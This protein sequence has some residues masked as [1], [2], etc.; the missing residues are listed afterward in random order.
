MPQRCGGA[1]DRSQPAIELSDWERLP[2]H[3]LL[4]DLESQ[5]RSV[6]VLLLPSP[7]GIPVAA[8]WIRD[9][10]RGLVALGTACRPTM[11][12]AVSK[13]LVEAY[14]VLAITIDLADPD[15][16][17]WR[18]VADGTLPAHLY[19]PFRADRRYRDEFDPQWKDIVDLP[20]V[21]QLYLDPVM[22]PGR[23]GTSLRLHRN[24]LGIRDS[25][26]SAVGSGFSRSASDVTGTPA[27]FRR[28]H[29]RRHLDCRVARR[30]HPDSGPVQQR[31]GS[32]SPSWR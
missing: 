14:A 25:R 29:H 16:P 10:R 22:A 23:R 20:T 17:T 24:T 32:L 13:A 15:G 28:S 1:G 18:S 11:E 6:R 8:V 7:F 26:R 12:A 27:D 31:P 4:G 5:T 21:A 19:K 2:A 30:P 3:R 9:D